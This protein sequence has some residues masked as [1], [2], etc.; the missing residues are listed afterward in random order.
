MS[1]PRR[2]GPAASCDRRRAGWPVRA[3]RRRGPPLVGPPPGGGRPRTAST[4]RPRRPARPNEDRGPGRR[5]LPGPPAKPRH[6]PG[7][8]ARCGDRRLSSRAVTAGDRPRPFDIHPRAPPQ[9]R[10]RRRQAE[11]RP[12]WPSP[13]GRAAAVA[14]GGSLPV[15]PRHHSPSGTASEGHP[16]GDEQAEAV[17]RGPLRRQADAMPTAPLTIR[18]AGDLGP[19]FK[20]PWIEGIRSLRY[21]AERWHELPPERPSRAGCGGSRPPGGR[22]GPRRPPDGSSTGIGG[23]GRRRGPTGPGS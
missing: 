10:P 22:T 8:P 4:T 21:F 23:I 16:M 11:T 13:P 14:A 5:R 6:G 2:H 12:I 7:R 15:R 3:A 9:R 20:V 19:F 1:G 17:G 18:A